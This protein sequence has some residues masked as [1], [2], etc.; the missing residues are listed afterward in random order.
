M[1][2]F[3]RIGTAAVVLV[4]LSGCAFVTNSS[5][6]VTETR[7]LT[8]AHVDNSSIFVDTRNGSIDIA[9]D[10]DVNEVMITARVT[11]AADTEVEAAKR[12]AATK[13]VVERDSARQ[14]TIR[15]IWPDN[16]ARS[17][18]GASYTIRLPNADVVTLDTSNGPITAR[19]LTGRLTADTSNG[20]IEV[21]D[22]TGDA[23]LDTSNGAI[24]VR[25]H[26]GRLVADTSNGGVTIVNHSGPLEV[27]TSNGGIDVSL[28]GD[29]TGPIVLDSSNG[30]IRVSVGPK[31]GGTIIFDTSNA[32]ITIND[33]AGAITEQ[34]IKKGEGRVVLKNAGGTS[35]LD[36]SNASITLEIRNSERI[37]GVDE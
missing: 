28:A 23:A 31:F 4:L 32:G 36:T 19:S 37:T 34:T 17:G 27:D 5:E 30:S 35:V 6:R 18:E 29:Q 9:A 1:R 8:A 33:R 21:T 3:V 22:H 11:A 7:T 14:L 15:T 20:N 26:K 2:H 24:V 12:L 16:R 25:N 10:D 13:I